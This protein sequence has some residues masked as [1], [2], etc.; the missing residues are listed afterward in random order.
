MVTVGKTGVTVSGGTS[1]HERLPERLPP[2]VGP[3]NRRNR[4]NRAGR[5]LARN[6]RKFHRLM[7]RGARGR[8]LM[9][10]KEKLDRLRGR[11]IAAR[12]S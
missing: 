3:N 12:S 10:I 11:L 7:S 1:L 2:L 9:R 8:T 6:A 4:I 5:K